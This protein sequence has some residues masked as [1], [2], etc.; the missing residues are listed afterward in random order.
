MELIINMQ[1]PTPKGTPVYS[2]LINLEVHSLIINVKL[3]LPKVSLTDNTGFLCPFCT[4]KKVTLQIHSRPA[5]IYT[6][7][8]P[9]KQSPGNASYKQN[10]LL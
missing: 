1:F 6:N 8:C 3:P 2:A 7:S 4:C 10:V 9:P 5:P